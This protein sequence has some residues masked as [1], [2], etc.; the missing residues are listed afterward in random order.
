MTNKPRCKAHNRDGKACNNYPLQGSTV[1]RM[2]GG[3]SPQ[4]LRG[5]R[6]RI[7]EQRVQYLAENLTAERREPVSAQWVYD[8]LLE[9]ARLTIA[10]RDILAE[11]VQQLQSLSRPTLTGLE[12]LDVTVKLFERA[13]ERCSRAFE[14]LARLDIDKRLNVLSE[15]TARRVVDILE[16]VRDSADLTPEQR[17]LYNETVRK[18]LMQWGEEERNAAAESPYA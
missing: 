7:T 5:A 13:M 11:Q 9:T 15:E 17:E 2:H 3:K 8:E 4:A 12:Q 18:E 1:C 10:W 16:R 6:R 14:Q